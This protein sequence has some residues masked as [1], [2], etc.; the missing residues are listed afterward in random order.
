MYPV[1]PVVDASTMMAKLA[2]QAEDPE[3]C[4][5][6]YSVCA[7]TGA[8]LRLADLEL[9]D[10]QIIDRFAHEAERYRAML[11]CL[12]NATISFIL[13]PFFLSMYYSSRRKRLQQTLLLRESLTL[14][15]LLDLDKEAAYAT[16]DVEEQRYR[17]KVFWL[18]FITE[19]GNAM[20][21]DI[22]TVLRDS[23]ALPKPDDDK[24]PVLFMGFLSLVRLFVAVEGTLIGGPGHDPQPFSTESF[25]RLQQQLRANPEVPAQS[26]EVQRTDICVT[27]QWYV[28]ETRMSACI[29]NVVQD[30]N[31]SLATRNEESVHDHQLI[32]RSII[33]DLSG[34]CCKRLS[35]FPLACL[36]G[37]HSGT[38]T[39]HGEFPFPAGVVRGLMHLVG[40]ENLR[41]R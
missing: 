24:D 6:A 40:A 41:D 25:A 20:Q 32:G 27:Q 37:I 34:T 12:D 26:S 16:L 13:I 22:A 7:A 15:E 2:E 3:T 31:A 4:A 21:Q 38:W 36:P 33:T 5:L 17:R 14:C 23:I 18:L 35:G 30:A 39:R 19:R 9:G 10:P 1:W 11:D 8:Q 28:R 29:T